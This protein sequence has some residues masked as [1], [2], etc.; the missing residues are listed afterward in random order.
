M[1]CT[2]CGAKLPA[3][4]IG[5]VCSTEALAG[6]T[7]DKILLDDVDLHAAEPVDP[8][9]DRRPDLAVVTTPPE[10]TAAIP[11]ALT[12][13][14]WLTFPRWGQFTGQDG[15]NVFD[16]R[17]GTAAANLFGTPYGFDVQDVLDEIEAGQLL[18]ERAEWAAAHPG[19]FSE[20]VATDLAAKAERAR[21]R[22]R[23]LR[24][25]LPPVE[26]VDT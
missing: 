15:P 21:S 25:L 24:A 6:V 9:A 12:P 1:R 7:P 26:G 23:R 2:R 4:A 14:M 17:H 5:H 19:T 16:T 13:E 8:L 20:A 10:R 18:Q 11:P 22:A 3:D